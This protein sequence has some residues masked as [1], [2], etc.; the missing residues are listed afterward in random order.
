MKK[1]IKNN[2]KLLL[3]ASLVC[4][5]MMNIK[6][7]LLKLEKGGIDY[8]HFDVMDNQF[9]P[10]FG[11]HPEIL[12]SIKKNTQIPVDVHLMVNNPENAIPAFIQ[13]GADIIVFHIESTPHAHRLIRQIKSAGIRAGIA[14]NP[15]TNLDVLDYLLEDIDMVM[16]MAINPGI[17]G[18]KLIPEMMKKISDLNEKLKHHKNIM[19]AIDGGVSFD[20]AQEMVKRGA[21]FLVC[22]TSTIFKPE[23]DVDVKIVELNKLLTKVNNK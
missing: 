2:K 15:A 13:A 6:G 1:T 7:E 14:I 17:L 18:H 4:A 12:Q 19:I 22:G 20:S 5:D 10:R 11:L 8:I 3:S 21:S 9:V 23:G 16:L